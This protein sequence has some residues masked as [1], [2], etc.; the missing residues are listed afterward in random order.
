MKAFGLLLRAAAK[1]Q[2]GSVLGIFGLVLMLSLSLFSSLTLYTSGVCS[3]EREMQRLGFGDYTIWT[4]NPPQGLAGEIA[5][6]PDTESV[7][8]QPLI[9]AGYEA[10]GA[11]SDNEGQL[12]VYDGGVP[13]RFIT[14]EGEPIPAPTIAP[15]TVYISPAMASRFGVT[16]GDAIRFTLARSRGVHELAVAGYFA[17]AFMGSS[18]IDMKSFLVSQEDWDAMRSVIGQ[19]GPSDALAR[20]GSMLHI[21]RRA[22]SPLTE[23]EFQRMV[24]EQTAVGLCTAFTYRQASIR[25]YLLLLQNIL[26]GV[27]LAFSAVLFL[28]SLVVIGQNLSAA[29]EQEQQQLAILRT[30]GLGGG[31]LRGG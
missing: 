11:Y 21:T 30:M 23:M 13:Y 14:A 24:Q 18:M 28:V 17:D 25:G 16:A 12:I 15:G 6:L 19:A 29:V 2:R 3:V 20:R 7:H 4:E 22:D 1:K 26:C 9:F 10:G 31:A 5:A 27:F 8:E